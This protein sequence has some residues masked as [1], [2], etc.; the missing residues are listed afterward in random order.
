M[1]R[2]VATGPVRVILASGRQHHEVMLSV[3]ADELRRI[4]DALGVGDATGTQ[5]R[6]MADQLDRLDGKLPEPQEQDQS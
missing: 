6:A 5:F 2:P 4:S 1:T 3:D